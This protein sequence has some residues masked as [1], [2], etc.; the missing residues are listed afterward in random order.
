M[1]AVALFVDQVSVELPPLGTDVGFAEKFTV[2]AGV[3]AVDTVTVRLAFPPLEFVHDRVKLVLLAIGP[4]V[5]V[6]VVLL[7]PLQPDTAGFA[8]AVQEFALVVV[9]VSVEEPC[10]CTW[11]GF[12]LRLMVGSWTPVPLVS[13]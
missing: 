11:T 5:S 8:L 13:L 6:P 3:V 2:G 7:D 4:T 9:Q 10:T 12:A 1:H